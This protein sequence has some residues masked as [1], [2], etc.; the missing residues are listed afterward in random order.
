MESSQ[1]AP[2]H[3]I[4]ED[5]ARAVL[6]SLPRRA[7]VRGNEKHVYSIDEL[8]N[9]LSD[10]NRQFNRYHAGHAIVLALREGLTLMHWQQRYRDGWG[11]Y[12][13]R[14]SD[15]TDPAPDAREPM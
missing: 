1:A 14:P 8:A 3:E 5:A 6:A 2:K 15:D 9:M 4:C 12:F 11:L 10:R 7:I 13:W